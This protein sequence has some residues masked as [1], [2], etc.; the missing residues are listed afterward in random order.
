[1]EL[2][3]GVDSLLGAGD[4]LGAGRH[5]R[6]ADSVLAL[7]SA[8]DREWGAPLVQRGWVAFETRRVRGLNRTVAQQWTGDG[9]RYAEAAVQ[10]S[11]RAPPAEALDLRGT[12]RFFRYVLNL[13][14]AP[15]TPAQLLAAAEAD[16]RAGTAAENP[17]RARAWYYL[18]ALYLRASKTAEAKV[19]AQAAIEA[20]P[21]LNEASDIL[22][23]LFQSSLDLGDGVESVRW[24]REA[25]GRFPKQPEFT[26]CQIELYA[27][28]DQKPDIQNAWRLLSQN[29]ALYPPSDTAYR[30]RR[31]DLLVAMALA[32]AGLKDSARA[33]ALRA[34][35]DDQ[36]IDPTHE[37]AYIE[38]LLRNMLGDTDE[39]LSR[40]SLFLATNPQERVNV[41]KD[42]T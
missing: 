14:A 24:C 9:L 39:A 1:R 32:R 6:E 36:A 20:D 5:L 41:A 4:S 33:V 26:E 40:L 12:L 10:L 35:T 28:K 18:S 37:F 15:L 2:T 16:L 34:R 27:L 42:S 3:R 13:D 38:M 23:R 11:P 31:G 8:L 22:W 19:A 17:N 7:A 21:Y 29:V 25:Y 30:R